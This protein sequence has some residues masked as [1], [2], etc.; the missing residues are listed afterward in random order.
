MLREKV[1]GADIRT[2]VEDEK[3]SVPTSP[4]TNSTAAKPEV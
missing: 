4:R 1:N 3:L 2:S